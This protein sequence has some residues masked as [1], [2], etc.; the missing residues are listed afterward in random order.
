MKYIVYIMF[1]TCCRGTISLTIGLINHTKRAFWIHHKTIR[2][3][4]YFCFN[5]F[6][7]CYNN[8]PKY[9]N[10]NMKNPTKYARNPTSLVL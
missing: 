4:Y 9:L 2:V 1:F 5:G 6:Q 3:A 8:E 10:N 7:S